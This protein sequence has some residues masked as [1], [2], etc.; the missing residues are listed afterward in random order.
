MSRLSNG[1]FAMRRIFTFGSTDPAAA[2]CGVPLAEKAKLS[3]VY[4]R[5]VECG[6]EKHFRQCRDVNC[7]RGWHFPSGFADN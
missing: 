2:L 5:R 1:W 4:I 7:N 6:K 3:P